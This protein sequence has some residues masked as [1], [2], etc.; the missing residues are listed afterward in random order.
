MKTSVVAFVFLLAL[1][2]GSAVAQS[3]GFRA[4]VPFAFNIS[5]QVFSPG[6]YEF[7]RPLGKPSADAEVGMVAVRSVD[8]TGYKA[9]MTA[10]ARP[11]GEPAETKLVFRKRNGSWQLFQVWMGGD[12]QQLQNVGQGSN[13]VLTAAEPEVVVAELR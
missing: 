10:L 11:V 3:R 7:Q 5:G 1:T 4:S 13:A 12:G 6:T 2:C 9:V 8:G